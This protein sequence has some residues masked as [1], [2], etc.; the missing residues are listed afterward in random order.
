MWSF[1]NLSSIWS[2]ACSVQTWTQL[3]GMERIGDQSL[4][5]LSRFGGTPCIQLNIPSR[6]SAWLCIPLP[7]WAP[8][9][10]RP[11][12]FLTSSLCVTLLWQQ[13]IQGKEVLAPCLH[14]NMHFSVFKSP[15]KCHST[16]NA[17]I[18]AT[19]SFQPEFCCSMVFGIT[20]WWKY[21]DKVSWFSCGRWNAA[22]HQWFFSDWTPK[23]SCL[24]L[25][26]LDALSSSSSWPINALL[27]NVM[28]TLSRRCPFTTWHSSS[29]STN[30]ILPL[31]SLCVTP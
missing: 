22:N 14:P 21:H 4:S 6:Q 12:P 2:R 7:I 25:R 8:F 17:P 9:P 29:F 1:S 15:A 31:H 16:S 24:R 26:L 3:S 27:I 19:C 11:L 5:L 20:I 28:L 10:F 30:S 13:Y 18:P 23:Y